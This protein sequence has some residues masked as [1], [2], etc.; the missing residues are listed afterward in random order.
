MF[1]SNQEKKSLLDNFFQPN[2]TLTY[3]D[4]GLCQRNPT[5]VPYMAPGISAEAVLASLTSSEP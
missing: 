1:I 3:W 2:F 4:L 5:L